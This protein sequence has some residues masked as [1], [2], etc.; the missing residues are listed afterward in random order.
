MKPGSPPCDKPTRPRV[1]APGSRRAAQVVVAPRNRPAATGVAAG[2]GEAKRSYLAAG[3]S[4][5]SASSSST[6][7]AMRAT[8]A[9]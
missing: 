9:R 2:L 8:S 4:F 5:V 6:S 3:A 1:R 7:R